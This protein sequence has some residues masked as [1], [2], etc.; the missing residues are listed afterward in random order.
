MTI[1]RTLRS[2]NGSKTTL[3]PPVSDDPFARIIDQLQ[4]PEQWAELSEPGFSRLLVEACMLY[5]FHAPRWQA[6][7]TELYDE[8]SERLSSDARLSAL[9]EVG[10]LVERLHQATPPTDAFGLTNAFAPFIG[11]DADAAVVSTAALQL[12]ALVPAHDG[13][14]LA[15]P[16]HVASLVLNESD[17]DRQL[18]L[19]TG[20]VATGDRRVLDLFDGCW[21]DLLSRSV[22][23]S[24]IARLAHV[25]AFDVVLHWFRAAAARDDDGV[26]GVLVPALEGLGRTAL[27]AGGLTEL[28]RTFPVTATSGPPVRIVRTWRVEHLRPQV[29]QHVAP[30]AREESY[31]RIIPIAL[32]AWGIDDEA[33]LEGLA[34]AIPDSRDVGTSL[35]DLVR[36]DVLPDWDRTDALLE[37]CVFNP[38]GPT[39]KQVLCT[40]LPDGRGR[41]LVLAQH[42]FLEP[43]ALLVA[44]APGH[45][46]DDDL[47]LLLLSLFARNRGLRQAV[48]GQLPTIVDLRDGGVCDVEFAARLF[49]EA[50][51]SARVAKLGGCGT[52]DEAIAHSR[53]TGDDPWTAARED[54]TST[55]SDSIEGTVPRFDAGTTEPLARYIAWCQVASD[56]QRVATVRGEFVKARSAAVRSYNGGPFALEVSD[57]RA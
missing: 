35:I 16:R 23:P 19:L 57:A 47:R 3:V 40:T 43:F 6:E 12:A 31:P 34:A 4:T 45:T 21:A 52:L 50:Q 39:R 24:L 7:L 51:Q 14:T 55:L 46:T 17:E 29:Q 32:R 44:T 30:L 36:L 41:A 1:S 37:W 25:T 53:R 11:L 38:F 54:F 42:H 48:C 20:L 33:Y 2:H 27:A 22:T 9:L 8:A 26:L 10:A 13:D 56:P 15:G 5:G 18:A 28:E 49:R